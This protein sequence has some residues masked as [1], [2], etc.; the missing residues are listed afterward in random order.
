MKK[1]VLAVSVFFGFFAQLPLAFS[2]DRVLLSDGAVSVTTAEFEAAVEYLVPET[3]QGSM[4]GKEKNMRGFLADYFTIKVMADAARAKG[5][6]K[7]P[8]V[9]V[10]QDYSHNRLLTEAL[11]D[12]YYA[13]AKEPNYEALAKEAYLTDSKR[14]DVPAQVRAEHILIEVSDKQNDAAALKKAQELYTEA[15]KGKKVFADLAKEHS[16]D[17]SAVDNSGDLGFFVREAMVE[18]FANAAFAMKKGEISQPIKTSFGYHIIHLLDKRKAGLQ[19]FD[20]VKP[21]LIDEQKRVFKDAKR[22]EIVSKFRSSSEIK[23]DEEA[24]KDFVKKMQQK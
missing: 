7:N 12:D 1:K 6:D 22:D 8:S 5:L 17:P 20:D 23:V 2:A 9:Q 11:V 4:R 19:P 21:F 13:S 10:Q 16:D 3:Q 15:K 18:P 24:M 14:F